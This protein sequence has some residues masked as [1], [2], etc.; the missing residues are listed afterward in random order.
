MFQPNVQPTVL[1]C[2][3][4]LKNLSKDVV[5]ECASL[6][7][8]IWK[9]P[10]WNED[11]WTIPR[12]IDDLR[13]EMSQKGAAGFLSLAWN[14]E[15]EVIGFTWG[16]R[17]SARQLAE[18]ASNP[19]VVKFFDVGDTGFYIDELGVSPNYRDRGIG[20]NLT[21]LLIGQALY[22]RNKKIFLRTNR[23]AVA[24]RS[25]YNDLGFQELD[26]TDGAY[27]ERNYWLLDTQRKRL[28]SIGHAVT[29][30]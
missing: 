18:L 19:E 26:L 25:V 20:K 28:T 2:P 4:D 14:R 11:F 29:F 24:A 22:Q 5:E 7:C 16:Y 6:Y 1:F 8:Q 23:K 3:L 10:P 12:V 9:E 27:K 21:E 30:A 17:V 15:V 13:R